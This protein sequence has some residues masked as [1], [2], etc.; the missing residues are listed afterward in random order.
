MTRRAATTVVF[1]LAAACA[2]PQPAMLPELTHLT[3][4]VAM[5]IETQHERA[6]QADDHTAWARYGR[7]LFGNGEMALA[8]KAYDRARAREAGNEF[9]S[10]YVAGLAASILSRERAAGHF[11]R[12]LSLRDDYAP[13][14]LHLAN[15]RLESGDLHA[16]ER[17]YSRAFELGL[18]AH[19]LLGQ[20]R[21]AMARG[22]N[23]RA[24]ALLQRAYYV[25]DR[26]GEVAAALAQVHHRL[27]DEKKARAFASIIDPRHAST[28]IPDPFIEQL[29]SR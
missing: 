2:D 18:T 14:H 12:A 20:G 9:E 6:I 21:V 13:A 15:N 16:A 17:H 11:E 4:A 25:D 3:P 27:G 26:F 22:E 29:L 1:V 10:S 8:E 23:E 7:L 24:Q 19:A 5:A 28:C